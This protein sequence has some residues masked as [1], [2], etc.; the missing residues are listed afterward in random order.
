[1]KTIDNLISHSC[2][3]LHVLESDLISNSR[4]RELADA[5]H[6]IIFMARNVFQISSGDY[7]YM[8]QTIKCHTLA[9]RLNRKKHNS[10]THSVQTALTLIDTDKDF[11]ANYDRLTLYLIINGFVMHCLLYTSD[12]ADE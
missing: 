8:K 3:Y 6:L 5:R 11:R 9:R 1:M 10:I 12:A 4:V 2:K 7:G